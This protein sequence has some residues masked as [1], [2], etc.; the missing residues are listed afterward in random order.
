VL[1]AETLKV[2]EIKLKGNVRVSDTTIISYLKTREGSDFDR[3]MLHEDLKSIYSSGLVVDVKIDVEEGPDGLIVTFIIKEKP[4]IKKVSFEGNKELTNETLSGKITLEKSQL[5]ST[6]DIS[7]NIAILK[8]VYS[9]K[10]YYIADV[11]YK[12]KELSK[13]SVEV[14]FVIDENKKV[15]VKNINFIGNNTYSKEELLKVIETTEGGLFSGWD[16]TGTFKE[17]VYESDVEKVKKFYKENGF[18][19]VDVKPAKVSL[20]TD[21]KEIFLTILVTEG[22][23]Y[24]VGT[25]KIKGDDLLY[26]MEEL[27][28]T[29]TLKEGDTYNES[30][31]FS[32]ILSIKDKYTN[33]GYAYANVYP[34]SDEEPKNQRINL[35]ININ[36][37][38]LVYIN[39]IK[40]SGNT[41]TRDKVIRRE[42]VIREGELY[43]RA[44]IIKSRENLF[45]LGFFEEANVLT[46][47]A[48]P[49]KMNLEINVKEKSTGSLNIGGGYSSTDKTVGFASV[50]KGNFRGLGETIKFE[51][52]LSSK[53]Q[54][55]NLSFYEPWLFDI[56]LSFSINLYNS[57]K[58]FT[59]Y[60]KKSTGGSVRLGYPL[61]EKVRGFISYKNEEV[62]ITDLEP[63]VSLFILEQEGFTRTSSAGL[64]LQRDT[65]NNRLDP[66]KGSLVSVSTEYA[67]GPFGGDNY[68]TKYRLKMSKYI[69][70][71][72]DHVV[73]AHARTSYAEGNEGRK[74]PIY[75]RY[76]L[77]GINSVRGFNYNAI[78]P[79][80]PATG[81]VIGGD[82]ELLFNFEYMFYLVKEANFKFVLFFDAG[83]A[84][85]N[86][87]HIELSKLRQSVGYGVR[88]ISPVGP[89]RLEWGLNLDPEPDE[90]KS[91][92]EFTIGTF[93]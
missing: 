80:D 83:N 40:I 58:E 61:F 6:E 48:G 13:N 43:N 26:P 18:I 31:L 74:L 87:E 66:S 9:A 2:S 17:E 89:I 11:K 52:E 55:F 5:L 35:I 77:G 24:R 63:G 73:M 44:S 71:W 47:K 30:R 79:K 88:W 91:Q 15:R 16:E 27:Y 41:S 82:K 19:K 36:K 46:K 57:R 7:E 8:E 1:F 33:I 68:Y 28:S 76:Y 75:E 12:V 72:S 56:P 62:E 60:L 67:G 59:D 69:N 32:D 93:F 85:D 3:D 64:T 53:K 92:W 54:D 45:F 39:E 29:L 4:V 50:S 21:K 25:I 42:L 14:V 65:R 22:M 49:D 37:N 86:G 10:G 81:D 70:P 34:K 23:F 51:T 38:E 90:A 78:G 20:S 84:F